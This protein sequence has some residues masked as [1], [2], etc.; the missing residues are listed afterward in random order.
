M[1]YV[2]G[3]LAV[4]L[5]A[6]VG[7]GLF[8]RFA[9]VTAEAWH[10]DPLTVEKPAEPNHYLL[11]PEGGDA[12]AP[13]FSAELRTVAAE[14]QEVAA[15]MPRTEVLLGSAAEG[16]MTFIARSRLMGFPDFVTIKLLED[17]SG[18][19]LVIFSRSKYGYSDMGVNQ[20]RVEGWL[21]ALEA[22]LQ[23]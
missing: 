15:E 8:F 17:E 4:V 1:K 18:T 16:H 7:A 14:L 11:R 9:P 22:R 6:L 20:E 3:F 5:L 2:Y 10:V 21:E 19:T 13:V 23:P 12:P